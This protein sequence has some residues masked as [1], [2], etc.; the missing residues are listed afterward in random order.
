MS[1]ARLVA[2]SLVATALLAPAAHAGPCVT[3]AGLRYCSDTGAN[4]DTRVPN[5]TDPA[6][7]VPYLTHPW[8]AG[9]WWTGTAG[10]IVHFGG[11]LVP[12]TPPPGVTVMSMALRCDL[13]EDG[14]GIDTTFATAPNVGNTIVLSQ[15]NASSYAG[16]VLKVC[17]TASIHWS[18][19]AYDAI[20]TANCGILPD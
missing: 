20:A 12:G 6:K 10:N 18:D 14:N 3:Q 5:P 17:M 8:D 9:C 19:G 2:G 7:V 13:V 16:G 11:H 1:Y 15:A 4:V